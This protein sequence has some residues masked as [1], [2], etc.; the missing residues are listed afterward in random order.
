AHRI[1]HSHVC[2]LI[3]GECRDPAMYPGSYSEADLRAM[4]DG[5]SRIRYVGYRA[6]VENVYHSADVVVVPSRWQEPLGLICLEAGACRK[7]VVATRVGG[8]PEIIEDGVN[9]HLVAAEDVDAL[10]SRVEAL[11]ADTAARKRM[12]E[13]GRARVEDHFATGPIRAFEALLLRHACHN[14]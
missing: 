1:T 11:V 4:A 7:P 14:R 13:A 8:I 9:G 2:F 10:T 3:A 5:E 6:D 12:G